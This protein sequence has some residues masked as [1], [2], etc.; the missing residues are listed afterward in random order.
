MGLFDRFIKNNEGNSSDSFPDLNNYQLFLFVK[1]CDVRTRLDEY[2]EI[3]NG[4]TAF[5]TEIL[6]ISNTEWNYVFFTPKPSAGEASPIWEYLNTLL[7]M[8]EEPAEAFAYA[9][10]K[11]EGELPPI[12]AYRD[13]D[14]KSGDSCTGIADGRQF[15]AVIPEQSLRWGE[16]VSDEFDYEGFLSQIYGIDLKDLF[17]L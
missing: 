5:S 15:E 17:N 11:Y 8:S 4:E 7:W 16:S 9:C 6:N 1:G 10:S 12:I 2:L 13:E 14:S 3:Y